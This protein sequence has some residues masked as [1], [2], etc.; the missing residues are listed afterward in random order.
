MKQFTL[1][2]KNE[3]LENPFIHIHRKLDILLNIGKLLMEC[4]ADT[5]RII[6]E[7]LKSATFMG[8]PHNYLNIH[9]SYTTI[10]VNL[11]HKE[12]SITVFRKTPVHVPNMA[13]INAV[14]KLTWRAFERHYSLTT[15]EQLISKLDCTIPVYPDW[16]K[17]FSRTSFFSSNV[18]CR[19]YLPR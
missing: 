7:M 5:N 3:V 12:R 13:M 17:G 6:E 2:E 15:Y 9:I 1:K 10:M 4:G 14:S 18:N 8:I 11:L 19:I 16:I